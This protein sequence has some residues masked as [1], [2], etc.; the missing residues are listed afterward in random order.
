MFQ[1]L[2]SHPD[3]I[4]RIG[5]EIIRVFEK[6]LSD[7]RVTHPMLNFLD[8]ILSSGAIHLLVSDECS[9]PDEVFA[10][11]SQD[12]KG[13]KKLYKLVSA[14]SVLCQ[15]I[16]VPKLCPKILSKMAIYLG[17]PH[18]HIRKSTASKLYEALTLYGD[19]S[20]IPDENLDEVL[21]LLSETDWGMPLNDVRPIRNNLC[22]L[23]GV[24]P[25]VSAVKAQ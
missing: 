11:V 15:L 13:S 22:I 6:H 9:F 3:D 1:Y 16:Q 10:L 4:P 5:E 7:D 19:A 14:I 12:M 18:V 21:N 23:M 24:K 17:Q 20:G 2:K 25:P 8:L